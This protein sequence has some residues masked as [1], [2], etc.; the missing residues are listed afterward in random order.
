MAKKKS[1]WLSTVPAGLLP[2]LSLEELRAFKGTHEFLTE[3]IEGPEGIAYHIR[4]FRYLLFF[5][6][7][8]IAEEKYPPLSRCWKDLDRVFMHAPPFD[9]DLFVQAWILLD[10]PFGPKGETALDYF[11]QFLAGSEGG[12]QFQ[13]FI[14]EARKSRLGLYQDVMRTKTVSKFR[15]LFT[16]RAVSTFRSVEEYGR[17]EILLVRTIEYRGDVFLFGDP[18]GWPKETKK[19]LQNMATKL[20]YFKGATEVEMYTTF[21]KLAGPYWMSCVTKDEAVP[22]LDPDHYRTYL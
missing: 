6:V 19:Q 21:M 5:A 16:G 1:A 22:I 10:F 11:E 14:D 9:D 15:E 17:G 7:V 20:F 2:Q 12:A 13:Y 18:K 4:G 8:C 3:P